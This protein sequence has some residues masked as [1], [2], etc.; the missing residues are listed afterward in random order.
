MTTCLH[1][2][3]GWGGSHY[4]H[5]EECKHVNKPDRCPVLGSNPGLADSSLLLTPDHVGTDGT[6]CNIRAEDAA[7]Q[8]HTRDP[9][10]PYAHCRTEQLGAR[11][12]KPRLENPLVDARLIEAQ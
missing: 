5:D 8:M 1:V 3:V 2:P 9:D 7:L 12:S 4:G 11:A 10:Y 6:C